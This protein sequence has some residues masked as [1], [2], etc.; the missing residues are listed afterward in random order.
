ME[1]NIT[2]V[3][4]RKDYV[5]AL[6]MF[7]CSGAL[8]VAG[9]W[10]GFNGGWCVSFDITFILLSVYLK[11]RSRKPGI[12]ACMCGLLTLVIS[13]G[14]VTSSA[15]ETHF[16]L[17]IAMC[18]TAAVWLTGLS[19]RKIPGGDTEPV[20]FALF[21]IGKV[22]GGVPSSV[23]KLFEVKNQKSKKVFQFILGAVCCIPVLCVVIPLLIDSDAAFE[24][25]ARNLTES[26]SERIAQF[27]ITIL[28]FP[29][30]LSVG[31]SLDKEDE[32]IK[33]SKAPKG[34]DTGFI[35]AF[36]LV[37]CL[38][39]AVYLFSQMAYFFSPFSGILP[40][41]YVYSYAEYA[42]RG[43]FEMCAVTAINLGIILITLSFSRKKD[44]RM[45]VILSATSV[46]ICLFTLF[47]AGTATAKMVM[48]I[49]E[50]GCTTNRIYA[51]I[52][53]AFVILIF[54]TIIIRILTPRV[55]VLKAAVIYGAV[56]A[57]AMGILN[58]N[59]LIAEYNYTA[60]ESGKLPEID[61]MYLSEL[62]EDGVPYLIKLYESGDTD[63]KSDAKF[64]LTYIIDELY[65]MEFDGFNEDDSWN[66][67]IGDRIHGTVKEMSIPR[68]RAYKLMDK[69]INDYP[70]CYTDIHPREDF[71]W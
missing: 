11:K 15:A 42:R 34:L 7:F 2:T 70:D 54:I 9:I 6:L 58:V 65:Y 30:G 46:F 38:C 40:E 59:G 47:M 26:F 21:I 12:F 62:G 3:T 48:Y 1:E 50:F 20:S 64:A 55:C 53:E 49:G 23:R 63:M 8:T 52:F 28:I 36:H 39:Y 29:I 18:I 44:G 57:A 13:A 71:L 25:L 35:F 61:V 33:K 32:E 16:I 56:L 51:E 31:F 68:A 27:V 5:F 14:F 4:E 66:G 24:G 22:L 43:F 10:S 67:K 17:F 69:Y 45:P 19:G 60:Y 37:L 41:G